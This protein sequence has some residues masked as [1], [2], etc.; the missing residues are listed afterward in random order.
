LSGDPALVRNDVK[1]DFDW[2][3]GKPASGLP[4]DDFSARW[5]RTV[6]FEE[7]T[8]RFYVWVDDGVRLWVDDRLLIDAWYDH[9]LHE[10]TENVALQTGEHDIRLEFYEHLF[11]AQVSLGW[12]WIGPIRY[13]EWKGE[14]WD[15]PNLEGDP[16]LV[17]NDK[18]LIFDWGEGKPAPGVPRD[19]FSA[20]WTREESFEGGTYR[21]HVFVDDGVRLWVDG[22]L[23]IDAWYDHSLHELTAEHVLSSGEHTLRLEYYERAFQAQISLWWQKIAGPHYPD[24]KAEYWANP[25]LQG[26][27][28]LVR[29]DV[30]VDFAWEGYAPAPGIP[31]DSFSARWTRNWRFE[32]GNYR[33]YAFADDGVRVYIGD[34]LLVDEWH[35][36]SGTVYRDD[37]TLVG[38]HVVRVEYYE[39]SGDARIRCWWRRRGDIEP[40]PD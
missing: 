38:D 15:N 31:T 32:P 29:N 5:T 21:F 4:S 26:D 25:D 16:V 33:F 11:K 2:G 20:R 7:G 37:I 24:W 39:H 35:E 30:E 9:S 18:E 23:L 6:R 34:L 8:Y 12:E 22:Y 36:A 17:R 1:L 19:D 27:P 40:I 10:L 28:L 14:Y 13:A 3:E